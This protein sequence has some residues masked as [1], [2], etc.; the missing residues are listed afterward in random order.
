MSSPNDPPELPRN[1]Y[2]R[3]PRLFAEYLWGKSFKGMHQGNA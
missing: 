1:P 2:Y 3:A